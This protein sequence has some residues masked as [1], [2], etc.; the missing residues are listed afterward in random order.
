MRS[1]IIIVLALAA[2]APVAHADPFVELAGGVMFPVSNNDWTNAVDVSPKFAA[3][4]GVTRGDLEGLLSLDWTPA[5]AKADPLFTDI[6]Y[7]R[8]RIL[9]AVQLR[10]LFAPHIRL[11]ARAGF[12]IDIAHAGYTV[13]IPLVGTTSGSDTDTGFA[14]EPAI[15]IWYAL[16][17][18][19]LGLELAL[20]IATHSQE[21]NAQNGDFRFH[22]TSV[23]IDLLATVRFGT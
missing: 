19:E 10:H 22:Y 11:S 5:Q 18:T 6:S 21:G 12:G 7:N 2:A 4:G 3:R 8:F 20:P 1:P 23:D 13:D 17:T 15:G 16:G 14:F 9:A